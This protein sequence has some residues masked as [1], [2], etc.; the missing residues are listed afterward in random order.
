PSGL[1]LTSMGRTAA[2]LSLF[3]LISTFSLAEGAAEVP[4]LLLTPATL[5]P[6]NL[7]PFL[8]SLPNDPERSLTSVRSLPPDAWQ[9][10]DGQVFNEGFNNHGFWFR[11]DI[12]TP[13]VMTGADWV[14]VLH[15]THVNE[16]RMWWID[17]RS[18]EHT[19]ELQSREN[20]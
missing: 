19:S 13:A 7:S 9:A 8:Y 4:A 15:N 20:L 17:D 5:M 16:L 12:I 11:A 6:G 10:P 14:A 1:G 2:L 3:W 18:E